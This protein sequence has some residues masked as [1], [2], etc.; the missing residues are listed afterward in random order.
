[1][2]QLSIDLPIEQ[3]ERFYEKWKIAELAV[4]GSILRGDFTPDSDVDFLVT[5]APDAQW[6]LPDHIAMEFELADLLGREVD[7]VSR[8]AIE[9][10]ENFIRRRAILETAQPLYVA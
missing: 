10:S 5:F 1:M 4:F 2:L 6:T 9:R 7:L 3:I 8:P